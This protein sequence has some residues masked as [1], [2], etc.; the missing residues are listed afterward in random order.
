MTET[1]LNGLRGQ[2]VIDPDDLH[3]GLVEQPDLFYHVSESFAK[4]VS[5]RDEQKLQLEELTAELD[6]QLRRAYAQRQEKSTEAS[7]QNA[8]R[9]M[10]KIRTA[11]R[12]FLKARLDADMWQALKEAFQQRSFMLRELV[13]LKLR[14]MEALSLE[15]GAGV[16]RRALG[17]AIEK[18][19]NVKRAERWKR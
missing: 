8:L 3:S 17:N 9:G 18:Q 15:S 11:E 13:S 19:N 1:P 16:Q 5:K 2:L 7:I 4:A 14:Q 12:E 6:Q 10:P